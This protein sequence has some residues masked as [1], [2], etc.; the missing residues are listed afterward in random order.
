M[1]PAS[2]ENLRNLKSIHMNKIKL[3]VLPD[4]ALIHWVNLREFYIRENKQLVTLSRSFLCGLLVSFPLTPLF[5]YSKHPI[6]VP[7]REI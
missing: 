3:D 6:P 4:A 7:T 1:I 2:V 5:A